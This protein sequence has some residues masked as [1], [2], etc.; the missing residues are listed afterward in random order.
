MVDGRFWCR[1][2]HWNGCV[3]YKFVM[4]GI[5]CRY[6][7]LCCW[8]YSRGMIMGISSRVCCIW[9]VHG[10]LMQVVDKVASMLIVGCTG[11]LQQ[12][13][14]CCMLQGLLW[15]WRWSNAEWLVAHDV[16]SVWLLR[17]Q[18]EGCRT[19]WRDKRKSEEKDWKSEEN[20]WL[21]PMVRTTNL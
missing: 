7:L 9:Y 20:S 6:D 5:Y 8:S 2:L 21:E 3:Y 18:S 13:Y 12:D 16:G 11:L 1:S 17:L 10:R 19:E 15:H 4:F 14:W